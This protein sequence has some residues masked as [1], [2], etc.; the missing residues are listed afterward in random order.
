[1][2]Y[3]CVAIFFKAKWGFKPHQI[4]L[5]FEFRRIKLVDCRKQEIE[6]EE[7]EVSW[8]GQKNKER[9]LRTKVHLDI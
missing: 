5:A 9:I 8:K 1:M 4:Q 7:E 6:E 3:V 2:A